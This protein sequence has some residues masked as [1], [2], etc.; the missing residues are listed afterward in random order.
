MFLSLIAL[1]L[2]TAVVKTKTAEH[3][4]WTILHYRDKRLKFY[5][6]NRGSWTS[7]ASNTFPN[8]TFLGDFT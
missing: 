5:Y 2:G 4:H 6:T 7:F 1:K 3:S 8:C